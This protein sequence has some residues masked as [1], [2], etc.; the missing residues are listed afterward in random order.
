MGRNRTVCMSEERDHID[1][2]LAS[3]QSV[4]GVAAQ[5]Q[6]TEASIRRLA[7]AQLV[8][9]LSQAATDHTLLRLGPMVGRL[10]SM[11]EKA[12]EILSFSR[13]AASVIV[14]SP[15]RTLST[16]GRLLNRIDGGLPMCRALLQ[17]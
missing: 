10:A 5:S 3:G 12:D 11:A 4:R 15:A 7:F 9:G 8:P 14:I 13:R 16:T 2:D 6:S 1:L 17:D